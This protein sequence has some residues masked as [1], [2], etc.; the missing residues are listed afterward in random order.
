MGTKTY[1]DLTLLTRDGLGFVT[2]S[3]A[4]LVAEKYP[5][6]TDIARKQLLWLLREFVKNQV[7]NL[8]T[9]VWNIL[10]HA[11]GGDVSSRNLA[12]IEGLLD[13]FIDHRPWL[14]KNQFLIGTVAYS[15]VR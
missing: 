8:E 9:L 6:F 10:R 7:L 12:L 11:S 13:I 3:L 15:Y 4:G 5:K 2:N 14:E 1:R